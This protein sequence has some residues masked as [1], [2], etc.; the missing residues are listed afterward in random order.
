LLVIDIR[1]PETAV[2]D[3]TAGL[4]RALQH[5]APSIYA[6]LLSFSVILIT[7]VNHH[8]HLKLI[9]RSNAAFL[10]A[11][12]FLLLTVAFIP[13]PTSL[14][15][16][17]LFSGH[18]APAVILYE[19]VLTLQ[20]VG[21]ILISHAAV[22]YRLARSEK[23]AAEIQKNGQFGYFAFTL[24]GLCALAAAWFPVSVALFTTATWIFWLI[25]GIRIKHEEVA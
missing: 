17:Y 23:A 12:G 16:E 3:S 11:N 19:V 14:L 25:F 21:W 6:F 1:I 7:W 10:Y 5:I 9:S 18:A 20:A 8:N 4:W 15:G 22:R 13:F 24:Y 2:V